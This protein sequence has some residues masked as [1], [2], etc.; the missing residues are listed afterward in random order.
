MS[1]QRK[2]VSRTCS[3]ISQR[4]SKLFLFVRSI[5]DSQYNDYPQ[6]PV[7]FFTHFSCTNDTNY[8]VSHWEMSSY[9]F[10]SWIS[11]WLNAFLSKSS[12]WTVPM[13]A[14]LLPTLFILVSQPTTLILNSPRLGDRSMQSTMM[15]TLVRT[16]DFKWWAILRLE[17]ARAHLARRTVTDSCFNKSSFSHVPSR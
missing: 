16:W 13:P 8:P 15:I 9:F 7:T 5:S 14:M 3:K 17:G 2:A 10:W 1:I 11:S 6:G 12:L 4:R